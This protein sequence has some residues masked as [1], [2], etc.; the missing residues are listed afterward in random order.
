MLGQVTHLSKLQVFHLKTGLVT[1]PVYN[2]CLET[3]GASMCKVLSRRVL[4]HSKSQGS[5]LKNKT[6]T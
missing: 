1:I 5:T 2:V 3:E 6:E 4:A